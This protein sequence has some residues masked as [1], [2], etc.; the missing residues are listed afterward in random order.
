MGND[1]TDIEYDNTRFNKYRYAQKIATLDG[2]AGSGATGTVALFTVTGTVIARV[3]AVCG[4]GLVSA[5]AGDIE[6]GGTG[7]TAAL[8][9][10]TTATNIDIGEIWHDATPDKGIELS[11]VGVENIIAEGLNIFATIATG[12]ITAG[13]LTFFVIWKPVSYDGNI[14]PA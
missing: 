5:G 6:V 11:S 4:T 3:I 9:A 2:G 1:K 12:D 14:V 10:N 7:S 8:I 13:E